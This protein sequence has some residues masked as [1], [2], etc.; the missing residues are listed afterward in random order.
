[1]LLQNLQRALAHRY[2]VQNEGVS[3]ALENGKIV[4]DHPLLE[5][6]FASSHVRRLAAGCF[7]VWTGS[8]GVGGADGCFCPKHR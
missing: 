8:G 6:A 2:P 3:G 4:G 5:D 1:M 7:P